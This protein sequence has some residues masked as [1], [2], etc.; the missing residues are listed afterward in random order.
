MP[1]IIPNPFW[2]QVASRGQNPESLLSGGHPGTKSFQ[3]TP[4][5][6]F[7]MAWRPGFAPTNAEF[8]SDTGFTKFSC[9][10]SSLGNDLLYKIESMRSSGEP[11]NCTRPGTQYPGTWALI[12]PCPGD[13]PNPGNVSSLVFS[14]FEFP[15]R[16]VA[17]F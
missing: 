11:D 6:P 5:P 7:Y 1:V 4:Q 8:N 3:M 15:C 2:P 13:L 10:N 9:K 16:T 14:H 12:V 17:T